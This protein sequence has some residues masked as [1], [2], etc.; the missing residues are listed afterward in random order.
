MENEPILDDHSNGVIMIMCIIFIVFMSMYF[1][2]SICKFKMLSRTPVVKSNVIMKVIS[3]NVNCICPKCG[4]KGIPTCPHC[5]VEMY[6]NGY[7][8]TFICTS[9]AHGGFPR[10]PKCSEYMTWIE[11]R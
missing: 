9:C 1:A 7:Q 6:W 8:G 5:S 10:C 4:F 11:N 2:Y 3:H